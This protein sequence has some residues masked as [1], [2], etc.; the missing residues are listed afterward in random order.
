MAE[1][2]NLAQSFF[3]DSKAVDSSSVV[4]VTSIELYFQSK[5][6]EGKAISG[7]NKPGVS[8][9]LCTMSNEQPALNTTIKNSR[10]RLEYDS[11]TSSTD[12]TVAT[13]FSFDK[14]IPLTT[15]ASY[16]MLIKFDGNDTGYNLWWGVSGE[17]YTN[18]TKQATINSGYT[19][20][21]F[22]KITNGDVLT[23]NG[24]ADLKFKLNIAK[25][26][27][28]SQTYKYKERAYELFQYYA[29]SYS[30]SIITGEYAYKNTANL[31]GS[32]SVNTTSALVTGTGT[33]FNTNFAV[34]DYIIV[35]D[36]T[37]SNTIVAL[38][39]S[40]TNS[41]SMTLT[42]NASFTNTAARIYKT[43]VARAYLADNKNEFVILTDSNANSSLY[44]SNGDYVK[45]VDSQA[46]VR[47]FAM[48]DFPVSRITSQMQA[49]VPSLTSVTSTIDVANS[50]Y[51]ITSGT[52]IN[53]PIGKRQFI[54]LYPA[55][56]ASRSLSAVGTPSLFTGNVS[57]NGAL[58]FTTTNQYC[59]P[60]LDEEDADII[61]YRYTINS[62]ATNEQRASGNAYSK[63]I[64]KKVVL[65]KD[66]DAEDIRVY[67]TAHLPAN[68]SLKLYGK[69]LNA[70]DSE[71]LDSKNWTPLEEVDAFTYVSAQENRNDVIEKQYK[72]P[73]YHDDETALTGHGQMTWS[74]GAGNTIISTSDNLSSNFGANG[75]A[76]AVIRVY[77]ETS[78]NNFFVSYVAQ[79]NSTTITIADTITNNSFLASGLKIAKVSNNNLNSAFL[80]PQNKNV[81][82]Y[83]TKNYAPK[84][85]YKSFSVKVVMLSDD[86]YTGPIV[87]DVKAVAVSA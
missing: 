83:Y 78:P 61:L 55:T 58:T 49:I 87:K 23:K 31:A 60:V 17:T 5:P 26:T 81:A 29:N 39:N 36:T 62:D 2:F 82:R 67:V 4:L 16:A 66:Q 14:P 76:N 48:Q 15:D 7:I 85:T 6:I 1:S 52:Q 12:G 72:I 79:S 53:L 51:A 46:Q 69:F 50:T 42:T 27:T 8:L 75:V 22:F 37:A 71:L 34:G 11:I 25:Y 13:K 21:N 73:Y 43:A 18:T 65:G 70:E 40:V 68:T 38:V 30:G 45:F 54:D 28:L 59:S 41:T 84:D 80:N 3:V 19:D 63:Y 64:S 57:V 10:A 35:S 77:Q 9:Y 44:F 47:I 32:V 33:T 86:S 24:K 56:I 74:G 20:G